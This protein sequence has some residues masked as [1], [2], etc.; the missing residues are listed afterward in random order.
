MSFFSGVYTLR[1]VKDQY[2]YLRDTGDEDQPVSLNTDESSSGIKF[3]FE[4]V[5]DNIY[6]IRNIRNDK[7][8]HVKKE[9]PNEKDVLY[10]DNSTSEGSQFYVDFGTNGLPLF[11]MK[12]VRSGKYIYSDNDEIYQSSQVE[13]WRYD[14]SGEDLF[15]GHTFSFGSHGQFMHI[16]KSG[17]ED[18]N[19]DLTSDESSDGIEFKIELVKEG[20]YHLRN[21]RN[22]KFI[23]VKK[24]EPNEGDLLYQDNSKSEG[25]QFN[26]Y[27]GTFNHHPNPI[28]EDAWCFT[29]IRSGKNIYYNEGNT[30]NQGNLKPS[31]E[32]RYNDEWKLKIIN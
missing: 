26:V 15:Q 7:F 6:F 18:K 8:I 27:P 12:N 2:I 16:D 5:Q 17:D 30:V 31:H 24:E 9:E 28:V 20:I 21:V 32:T 19:V 1:N 23:H 4:R 22:D 11:S 10:Q 29:S 14:Q 3:V 13:L 25:S